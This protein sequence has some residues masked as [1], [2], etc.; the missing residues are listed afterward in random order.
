MRDSMKMTVRYQFLYM[1]FIQAAASGIAFVFGM[2]AFW[3]FTNISVAKEILSIVFMSLNFGLL[4]V[5]SK[6]FAILDNKPYTPLKVSRIKAVLF[7]CFIALVNLLLVA[8]FKLVW[9][10]YATETGLSGFIPIAL[11]AFFYCWSFPYNGI[12]NMS[13][14]YMTI[15]SVIA[16]VVVPVAATVTGYIAGLNKFEITEKIDKFIY[17]KDND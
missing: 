6:R 4:Y 17:E 1:L 16:M 13:N 7:G 5:T 10:K 9:I 11:N 8:V 2:I 15:Y 3:Y 12:M 14:G